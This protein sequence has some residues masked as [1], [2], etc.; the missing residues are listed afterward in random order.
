M[1]KIIKIVLL[2]LL[3]L[4]AAVYLFLFFSYRAYKPSNIEHEIVPAALDYF[5]DT[6]DDCRSDFVGK[7]DQLVSQYRG[8]EVFK[9]GVPSKIDPELTVDICYIPAQEA[10][11]SLLIIISGTHGV[12]GFAGSA[13]QSMVI[14][15]ILSPGYLDSTGLLL[16]HGMNPYGM[17]YLRRVTENNI[18][19]NRNCAAD[20]THYDTKNEGYTQVYDMLTPRGKANHFSFRSQHLHMIVIQK[21]LAVSMPVLRQ[22]ILQGQYEYPEGLFYGGNEFEPQI[23]AITPILRDKMVPYSRILTVDLHTGYGKN[24]TLHLF[25]NPVE[26]TDIKAQMEELFAGYTIDWGDTTDFYIILGSYADYIGTLAPGKTYYPMIIEFG[27]LDS[28]Q[29]FGSIRSLHNLI[30]ENQGF[31]NGY[32]NETSEAKISENLIEM[33]YPSNDTWRSKVITDAKEIFVLV[34]ERLR[35]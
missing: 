23:D 3:G 21:I 13:I 11:N 30:L 35:T 9:L 31:Q 25:P 6:Y 32:K 5:H 4:I 29:T 19:L 20:M 26:D 34:F 16:I 22:A 10:P 8:V 15:E 14:E 7:I 17:K 27:T 33:F 1:K 28:Q 12:E 2:S 24:G 18:D